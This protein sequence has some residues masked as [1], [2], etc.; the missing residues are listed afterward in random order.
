MIKKRL[1]K[2]ITKWFLSYC[3]ILVKQSR[4]ERR[5]SLK[6]N[7]IYSYVQ[8]FN[9]LFYVLG[10]CFCFVN[11]FIRYVI[12]SYVVFSLILMC[13]PFNYI[14]SEYMFLCPLITLSNFIAHW[15]SCSILF[16]RY[17]IYFLYFSFIDVERCVV[18]L[19]FLLFL[20]EIY[21]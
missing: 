5:L 10:F 2:K 6:A 12:L 13:D 21:R 11:G 7:Y 1:K 14:A 19:K 15:K 16:V 20:L 18:I 8:D 9:F 3:C 17:I 4:F